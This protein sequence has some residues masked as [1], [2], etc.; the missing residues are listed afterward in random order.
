MQVS[1]KIDAARVT[2][3]QLDRVEEVH[4]GGIML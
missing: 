2:H 4:A 1:L 3:V